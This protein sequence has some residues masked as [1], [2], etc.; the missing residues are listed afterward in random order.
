MSDMGYVR[1]Q[2]EGV[3]PPDFL[4]EGPLGR[5]E[6]GD[7]A[8]FWTQS[9]YHTRQLLHSGYVVFGTDLNHYLD[10]ITTR[11]L[12]VDSTQAPLRCY[13][14][15]SS[16]ANAYSTPEGIIL[17]TLG[18][19]AQLE[20]EAELAFI[21]SHE[22]EHVRAG[23]ARARY[24]RGASGA[25][26]PPG[27]FSRETPESQ[28]VAFSQRQ[29][30][31][32]DS[33]ALGRLARAGFPVEAA[34]W[35]L[36]Y[37]AG[38]ATGEEGAQ[39]DLLGWLRQAVPALPADRLLPPSPLDSLP[40]EGVRVPQLHPEPQ[41]RR[42]RLAVM[43]ERQDYPAG[44]ASRQS[45]AWFRMSQQ[46]A[47]QELGHILLAEQ[48][49]AQALYLGE[50]EATWSPAY[51]RWLRLR[52]L[53][54][55]AIYSN[56]GRFWDV[57]QEASS[58]PGAARPLYGMLEQMEGE[59]LTV[60]A[61]ALAWR[62]RDSLARPGEALALA[63][64]LKRE[65]DALYPSLSEAESWPGQVFQALE[66]DP[67][68]GAWW[69]TSGATAP[70]PPAPEA[71][72]EFQAL[73]GVSLGLS[74]VV[75]VD[76]VYQR[77]DAR[78]PQARLQY[79][80]SS[81]AESNWVQLLDEQAGL[82]GLAHHMLSP[83]MLGA[84]DLTAFRDLSILQAWLAE[85]QALDELEMV[86][87]FQVEVEALARRYGTSYFVWMGGASYTRRRSGKALIAV[88]GLLPPVLPYSIYYLLTP[89]YDTLIYMMVY[90][91]PRGQYR[92]IYPRLIQMRDRPDVL[93]S[94]SYDLLWQ[95][96]RRP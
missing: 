4:P 77:I 37:P 19:L 31:Q 11:L 21:L 29:E 52:A 18:L 7:M 16:A 1:L 8:G 83:A 27:L 50:R 24:E 5:P 20:T 66:R 28:M 42:A 26:P 53:Y 72:S 67:Y 12:A 62:W 48:R 96:R 70:T 47:R 71:I 84:E 35:A 43:I 22:I 61:L 54:S 65:T 75:L 3:L 33:A 36:A 13:L 14:L 64:H 79:A 86:S 63:R 94:V 9:R 49:Y 39:P 74:H 6:G 93:K 17:V 46:R 69:A 10:E 82:A 92:L 95:V 2:S 25:A 23:H 90:D 81:A 87:L 85:Q 56:G 41:L 44:N 45:E 40:L 51:R 15:R 73:E 55:L 78:G 32:A 80:E 30:F 57:H 59:G 58:V 88:M 34:L 89:R 76:P 91:L 60:I 68:F 38:I